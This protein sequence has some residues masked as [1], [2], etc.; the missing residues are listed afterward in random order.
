MQR[1]YPGTLI[2]ISFNASSI[3]CGGAICTVSG[4]PVS[5]TLFRLER[6]AGQPLAAARKDIVA[7]HA[8]L[9]LRQRQ[10]HRLAGG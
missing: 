1:R 6:I 5:S 4:L 8:V 9:R 7:E 10:L 2:P 3:R